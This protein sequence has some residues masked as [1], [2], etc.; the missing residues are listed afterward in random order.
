MHFPC[1]LPCVQRDL[2]LTAGADGTARLYH[3]LKRV[4]LLVVEPTASRLYGVQWS[5][6]RPLVFGVATGG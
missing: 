2:F 3:S 4:P 1:L 6:A 5:S